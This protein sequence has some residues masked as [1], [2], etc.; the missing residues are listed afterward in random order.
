MPSRAISRARSETSITRLG[1]Q[2]YVIPTDAVESDGTFEWS[3]TTMVV[4]DVEAMGVCG[5]GYSYT[6][7]AAVDV[8]DDTLAAAVHGCDAMDIPAAWSAMQRAVRNQG[9]PG[10]CASAIAAVDAALWDLKGK[11]LDV[12]LTTLLGAARQAIPVYGSGGF[13]SYSIPQLQQQL[14]GWV[15][16]G[17]ARVKMKVGRDAQRDVERVHAARVAIGDEAELFVD[18]NGAWTPASAL[19]MVD[20]FS[21]DRIGWL[22]EPVSSDDLEGLARVRAGVAH[23]VEVAAGEYGYDIF[24]FR[25]MLEAAAVDVLQADAT[26]CGGISGFLQV[27]AL[28]EAFAMPLSAHTAPSL[29]A[30]PCCALP[31]VRHVEY[32]HDHVRI[33]QMLFDGAAVARDG[34]LTPDRSRPGLGLDFKRADAA[35]YRVN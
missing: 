2:A 11:L 33:E 21:A 20:R 7:R 25:R 31:R 1:A 32:F 13:T 27:G 18:A 4:A 23:G 19:A 26:R 6:A 12:P 28:C 34:H 29:H 14:A 22:E 35:P 16:A 15:D 5:V 10:I 3:S 8:I 30:A 24:Y 9:R 17:I